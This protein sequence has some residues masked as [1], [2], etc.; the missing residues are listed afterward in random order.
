MRKASGLLLGLFL[1]LCVALP[2]FAR[3]VNVCGTVSVYFSPHGGCTEAV[4]DA[5]GKGQSLILVQAYSMTSV[6]IRD[7][8]LAAHARGVQVRVIS[9]RTNEHGRGSITHDLQ[10]AGIEVV[11]DEVHRIAHNK[12]MVVDGDAVLTGS[13]NWT[14]SAENSNAENLI[15]LRGAA[16]AQVYAERWEELRK[17]CVER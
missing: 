1:A 11:Y 6:P 16:L 5:I 2:C 15:I 9:D 14:A 7:A 10:S 8:L 17:I 12:V 13:F 3:D 4:V